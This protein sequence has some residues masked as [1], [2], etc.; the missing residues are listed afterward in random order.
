MLSSKT[1]KKIKQTFRKEKDP[2]D[3]QKA[4]NLFK[5]WD[6]NKTPENISSIF[7]YR[8]E[9]RFSVKDFTDSTLSQKELRDA[10]QCFA[11]TMKKGGVSKSAEKRIKRR[12]GLAA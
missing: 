5:K 12:I 10:L 4:E 2:K 6:R 9:K 7:E 8:E 1:V 3:V 11:I